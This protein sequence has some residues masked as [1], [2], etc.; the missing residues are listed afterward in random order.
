LS[1]QSTA[2]RPLTVHSFFGVQLKAGTSWI[3]VEQLHNP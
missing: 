3:K 2:C 1:T